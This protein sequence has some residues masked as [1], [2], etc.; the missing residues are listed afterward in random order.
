MRVLWQT[1]GRFVTTPTRRY[2]VRWMPVGWHVS[3]GLS[4]YPHRKYG[5]LSVHLP[6]GVLVLGFVGRDGS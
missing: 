5:H 2:G 6:F 1:G 3:L 4:A